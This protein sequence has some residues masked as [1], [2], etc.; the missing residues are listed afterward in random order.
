MK[1]RALAISLMAALPVGAAPAELPPQ[2]FAGAQYVDSVGCVFRRDGAGNWQARLTRDGQP[3]CGYAPTQ[4]SGR[5]GPFAQAMTPKVTIVEAVTVPGGLT[6]C[7]NRPATAQR[8]LLSDGRVVMRCSSQQTDPIG[9]INDAGVPGLRVQGAAP[10]R[11]PATQGMSVLLDLALQS[12]LP[13]ARAKAAA[14]ARAKA[15]VKTGER[16]VQI[17]AFGDPDNAQKVKARIRA[18]GLPVATSSMK[19]GGKVLELIFSGPFDAE[20]A[21]CAVEKLREGGFADA[22]I[23]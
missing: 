12:P 6:S 21:K 19:R 13:D 8:Y 22:L 7:P 14:P 9:F 5:P 3:L 18:L 2:G 10:D 4:A 17:G 15:S 16:F 20:G 23:R 1:L 11:L